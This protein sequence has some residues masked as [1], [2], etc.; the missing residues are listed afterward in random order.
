MRIEVKVIPG[1]S[2]RGVAGFYNGV[3]KVKVNSAPEKGK[4]NGELIEILSGFFNIRKK[5]IVIL[6]GAKSRKKTLSIENFSEKQLKEAL[7]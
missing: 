2:K 1:V 4:A 5:N 3:L 7:K 6:K